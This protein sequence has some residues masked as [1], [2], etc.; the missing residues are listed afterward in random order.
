[1]NAGQPVLKLYPPQKLS[2]PRP[3]NWKFPIKNGCF[4][5]VSARK[6]FR[7]LFF[8]FR[9]SFGISVTT[10]S[11]LANSERSSS[12]KWQVLGKNCVFLFFRRKFCH[13]VLN[14]R[15]QHAILYPT[16]STTPDRLRSGN[17]TNGKT[18]PGFCPFFSSIAKKGFFSVTRSR[19]QC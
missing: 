7:A 15:E 4:C 19:I 16:K 1:M 8:L 13:A 6:S 10:I 17:Q 2:F 12:K 18:F 3:K 14:F 9:M 11:T 5:L